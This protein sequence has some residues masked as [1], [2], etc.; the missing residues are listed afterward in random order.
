MLTVVFAC[1]RNAG[2]SQ[3]AAALFNRIADP[4]RARAISA[5]TAPATTVHHEVVHAMRELGIDLSQAKPQLLTPERAAGADLLI[6]MGCG[7]Q[8]PVLPGVRRDDWA[9]PDPK[10]RP[11][12]EVRTI[13]DEIGKRVRSLAQAEGVL[14]TTERV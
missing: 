6:T 12:E 1:V 2:R 10:G 3:M 14:R 13:R 8:C 7:D 5:G 11:L 9:L 4:S